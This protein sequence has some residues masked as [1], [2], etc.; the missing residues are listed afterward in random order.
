MSK[1]LLLTI[2]VT[3]ALSAASATPGDPPAPTADWPQWRGPNR[4]GR[5]SETGLL[6]Q[7]PAEGPSVVWQVNHVGVGYSSLAV[8]GDRIY[9]Q[10]DLD[11]VEH[12]LAVNAADGS[13]VWAVQPEPVVAKLDARLRDELKRLDRDNDG[14]ISEVEA[15]AR[16]GWNFNSF[17][18][19]GDGDA[20][21]VAEQRVERLVRALDKDGDKRLNLDEAGNSFR[22][23]FARI[24]AE[25]KQVA[26]DVL[27]R[28]RTDALFKSIDK[29]ADGSITRQESRG[30]PLD[31]NFNRIDRSGNAEQ[32]NS[33]TR[34]E[35]EAYLLRFEKGR[36]GI[37]TADELFR[38][39]STHFAGRDGILTESELRSYLGGYRNGMGDGPRGTPT[40]VGDR[41]YVEG[42]VGDVTCLD[43]ATG[44]TI[45]HVDLRTLGGSI[46][47]WG[48]SESPLVVGDLV[49]VTPGGRNGTIAALDRETGNV[50]WR[51]IEV[52]QA[53]HYSSPQVAELAGV[54]QIVQF[55]RESVFGVTLDGSKLLW[56]YSAANN[57]TANICTPVVLDDHV[58]ASSAYGVGGGLVHIRSG[59]D[60]QKAEEVYF[61]K[62]MANHHGG[63]VLVGDHMYG[64][65]NRGLIAMEF[66]SGKP[67]WADRS[68]G[69]GSLVFAD[70]MLYCLGENHQMALV[71]A[72]TEGYRERG[73]FRIENLGQPS[74][75]H[76]V[77]AGGRLYI[78]NQGRL[79]AYDIAARPSA[80]LSGM[81]L[82]TGS[83]RPKTRNRP[84]GSTVRPANAV[85]PV[86][87]VH[88]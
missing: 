69:K 23:A 59:G 7:W 25:D 74:W 42:A 41:L 78:R 72:T 15:V 48:Y 84:V 62:A 26:A 71:E 21:L 34:G 47:G 32:D 33:V 2:G 39:Y 45:W 81:A 9:T 40:L 50:V 75:A 35:L 58:F 88:N 65:G 60:A 8:K 49:I 52:T 6:K 67:A 44:K 61:D 30:T 80:A 73:R 11:G 87:G 83:G 86:P 4:D 5:S 43:A 77:V 19:P 64:F 36:D 28:E 16:L 68:V 24:D 37:L 27:A 31:P 12:T 54:R 53:A 18:K 76:P 66:K 46:P 38:H 10:G 57:G 29:D 70:G 63:I 3:L 22:D 51:S 1:A 20:K 85:E 14:T 82:A 17:D 55:A 79:T 56:S 13:V